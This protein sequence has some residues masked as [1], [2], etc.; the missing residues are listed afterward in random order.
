MFTKG[1]GLSPEEMTGLSR[2]N[3][4]LKSQA[5]LITALPTSLHPSAPSGTGM[6]LALATPAVEGSK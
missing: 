4:L 5:V 1:F 3:I 6:A 2:S